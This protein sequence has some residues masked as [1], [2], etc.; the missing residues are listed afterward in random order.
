MTSTAE[1]KRAV[2]ETIEKLGGIDIIIG[3]AVR[4]SRLY[5]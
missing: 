3:N 5:G 2:E 1:A 4:N